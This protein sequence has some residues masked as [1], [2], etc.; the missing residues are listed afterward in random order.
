MAGPFYVMYLA[1]RGSTPEQI[2]A[3]MPVIFIIT[4]LGRIVL[5]AAIGLITQDV[6][7]AAA[8][9]APV[10]ALGL[11]LGN[12]WHAKISRAQAVRAIGAVLTLSGASLLLRAL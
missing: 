5:F 6:L 4:T 1:G 9:L 3:T 11:W 8:L 2:R 7:L 12:R 10:M